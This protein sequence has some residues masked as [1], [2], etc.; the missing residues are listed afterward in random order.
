MKRELWDG[1]ERRSRRGLMQ[2]IL[3]FACLALSLN[4][5]AQGTDSALL[6]QSQRQ[7][8]NC[9]G[10]HRFLPAS[11]ISDPFVT[12]HF[13][14]STGGGSASGLTMPVRNIQGQVVDSL[15]GDIA[16]FGLGFEYQYAPLKWLALRA[17]ASANGR[18]GTSAQSVVASGV[19]ALYGFSLGGTARVWQKSSFIVSIGGDFQRNTEYDVDPFGFVRAV[20]RDGLTDT[21][22]GVLLND[23]LLNRYAIGPRAAW[24]PY[25]WL[26]IV[27]VLDF[28]SAEVP[29]DDDTEDYESVTGYAAQTSVDFRR[30][31]SVPIGVSLGWRGQSGPGRVAS[32]GG[33]VS[34]WVAG[35]FYTGRAGFVIGGEFTSSRV[36]VNEPDVPKL[37]SV[38]GR[39]VTR[40]EF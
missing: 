38:L 39:L 14:S 17:T 30:M 2:A 21:T 36:E 24:A 3:S 20:V 28:G 12:T 31:S 11:N 25:P 16:F 15:E 7:C 5:E 33:T 22:R 18:V 8:R 6:A 40:I 27:G 29:Q 34:T 35:L 26:G 37:S 1:L 13:I 4:V 19:S 32:L 23:V 9:L 10:G